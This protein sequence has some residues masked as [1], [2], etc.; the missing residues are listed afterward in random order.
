MTHAH[1]S[2]A[3]AQERA[4]HERLEKWMSAAAALAVGGAFFAL[5][6]WPLRGWLGLRVETAGAARWRR[7]AGRPCALACAVALRCRWALGW[8]AGGGHARVAPPHCC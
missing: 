7:L 8:A 2:G 5:W 1:A 4:E 6:F 3:P